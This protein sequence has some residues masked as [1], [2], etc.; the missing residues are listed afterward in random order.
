MMLI[1]TAM[2][3]LIKGKLGPSVNRMK[4]LAWV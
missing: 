4:S 2:G 1:D 3:K